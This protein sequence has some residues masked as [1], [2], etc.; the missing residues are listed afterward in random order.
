LKISAWTIRCLLVAST[1]Q[2]RRSNVTGKEEAQSVLLLQRL[3]HETDRR[4]LL[5]AETPSAQALL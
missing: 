1:E 4:A 5:W 3:L 2:Y